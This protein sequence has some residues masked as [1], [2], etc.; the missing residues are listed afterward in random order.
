M[1]DFLLIIIERHADIA[2]VQTIHHI[3]V[4]YKHVM[5]VIESRIKYD[6]TY[7]KGDVE[8]TEQEMYGNYVHDIRV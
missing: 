4:T 7:Q 5:A 8:T 1:C 2:I 3:N 6:C